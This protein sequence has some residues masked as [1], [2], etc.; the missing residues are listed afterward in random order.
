MSTGWPTSYRP[1][2][3]PFGRSEGPGRTFA[4]HIET[5]PIA[6]HIVL[7]NFGHV[8]RHIVDESSEVIENTYQKLPGPV[9]DDVRLAQA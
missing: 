7:L 3:P 8:V 9:G 1:L 5:L 6:I 2:V 4:V